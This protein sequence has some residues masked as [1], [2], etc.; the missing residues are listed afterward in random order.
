[1]NQAPELHGKRILLRKPKEMDIEDRLKCGYSYE[2]LHML[3]KETRDVAA[4]TYEVAVE[5]YEGIKAKPLK[6]IIEY[7]E[8][9][10]GTAGLNVNEADKRA[11]YSVGIFDMSKVG[12][13]LGEEVTNLVL[14]YAF[15]DLKLHRV[16]LRVLDY[17]K[18]AIACYEKC[19]FVIEGM[20]REGA[21]IDQRW[22]TD[23][24]MS[25]LEREYMVNRKKF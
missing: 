24:I 2:W 13:G 3:G 19:G 4:L 21:F 20:E 10:I 12:L 5:W 11:R 9:C 18:R 15:K 17:N 6:W 25:I 14:E 16:D 22:E 7:E 8:K 1:M 23:I